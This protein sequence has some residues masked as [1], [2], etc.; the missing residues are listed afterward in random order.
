MNK[1]SPSPKVKRRDNILYRMR[2]KGIRCLTRKKTILYPYGKN[3]DAVR[4]IRQL[5]N[6]YDFLI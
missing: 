2:K 5:R 3:P 6:E 4:Q 1:K